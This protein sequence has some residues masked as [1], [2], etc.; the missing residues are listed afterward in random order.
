MSQFAFCYNFRFKIK[1]FK[2]YFV[3]FLECSNFLENKH[4][5]NVTWR[6]ELKEKIFFCNDYV[7]KIR[8][9]VFCFAT[10]LNKQNKFCPSTFLFVFTLAAQN[11]FF[12]EKKK[13][14]DK[15]T[16]TNTNREMRETKIVTERETYTHRV[17]SLRIK[18]GEKRSVKEIR[19]IK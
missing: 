14:T 4:T 15:Q 17:L 13:H 16:N 5:K 19:E 6:K 2:W 3:K 1:T 9:R 7:R 10:K 8:L 18:Y 11:I 12:L